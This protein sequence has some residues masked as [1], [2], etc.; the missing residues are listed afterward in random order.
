VT[1]QEQQILEKIAAQTNSELILFFILVVVALVVFMIPMYRMMMKDRADKAERDGTRQDKYIEREKQIIAVITA[2][3]E[4]ISGL[5][6]MLEITSAATNSSF[7]RLHERID[8][9]CNNCFD[10]GTLLRGLEASLNE[11]MRNQLVT[12]GD[13]KRVLLIVDNLPHTSS[14]HR[15]DGGKNESA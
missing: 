15:M 10:H 14:I 7:T 13:V 3:T 8:K 9:Q 5:K 2:N 4:V 11:I 12:A 6:A 1:G